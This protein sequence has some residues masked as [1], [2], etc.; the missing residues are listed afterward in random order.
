MGELT[1][2]LMDRLEAYD[3]LSLDVFDTF[4]LRG[5]ESEAERYLR[6]AR[7]VL[8]GLANGPYETLARD[9]TP[10]ELTV[11]RAKALELSYR[12]RKRIANS[13]EGS[14]R[15]VA[16]NVAYSLGQDQAFALKLLELE[17]EFETM[18]L[19]RNPLL[20]EVVVSFHRQGGRVLLISDMYL[21]ANMIESICRRVDPDGMVHV[22][23]VIS[24][25][26]TIISKRSGHIFGMVADTLCLNPSHTVHIGDNFDSDVVMARLAGWHA[27][28]FP[29]S[30][31][32]RAARERSLEWTIAHF[33]EC[34]IDSRT[35]AKC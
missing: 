22:D 4:L 3:T 28:H 24:S 30:R 15:E 7:F 6:W 21:H 25:A 33:D 19:Q 10:E 17:V 1:S 5:P 20:S 23:K 16:R 35:W 31:P 9:T 12:F 32:E 34:G 11:L 2:N 26:D 18:Q 8:A 14:I 27:M 13:A 29:V